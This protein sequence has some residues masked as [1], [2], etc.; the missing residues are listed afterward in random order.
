MMKCSTELGVEC[1]M[2]GM[3]DTGKLDV[4]AIVGRKPFA[5]IFTQFR[6]KIIY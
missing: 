1:A 4:L 5:Q 2:M 6:G 3:T